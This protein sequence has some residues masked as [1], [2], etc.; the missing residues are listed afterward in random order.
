M[1]RGTCDKGKE[2]K[3]SHDKAVITKAVGEAYK[4]YPSSLL[5]HRVNAVEQQPQYRILQRHPS[6]QPDDE[7][8]DIPN[9]DN[10]DDAAAIEAMYG[11]S[12]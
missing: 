7:D 8:E 1:L 4:L 11:T 10:A 5:P 6:Q 3:F 12:H 9:D 2:C